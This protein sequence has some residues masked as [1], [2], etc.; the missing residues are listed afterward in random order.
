MQRKCLDSF[1]KDNY[2]Y[3]KWR[4]KPSVKN[5][6]TK[7]FHQRFKIVMETM[8]KS[9]CNKNKLIDQK[10]FD[11]LS[12][13]LYSGTVVNTLFKEWPSPQYLKGSLKIV[14]TTVYVL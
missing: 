5:L 4:S 9:L 7:R 13:L 10:D 14:S 8:K 2:R 11:S 6:L 3:V 12:R 1:S